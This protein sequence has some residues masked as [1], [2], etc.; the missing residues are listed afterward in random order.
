MLL[1][2]LEQKSFAGTGNSA[3]TGFCL[4]Q[5]DIRADS[6]DAVPG[7]YVVVA[8][9]CHTQKTAGPGNHDGAEIAFRD[10]DLN[11]GDKPQS[12]TGTDADDFLALEIGR[13]SCRERV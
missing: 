13:A 5:Y 4:H 3:V 12:L 11:I 7:D 1:W 2:Y 6:F 10:V 8:T 9:A